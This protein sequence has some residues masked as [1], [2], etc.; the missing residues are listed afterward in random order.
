MGKVIF[1]GGKR[2]VKDVVFC[3]ADKNGV[4]CPVPISFEKIL[5]VVNVRGFLKGIVLPSGLLLDKLV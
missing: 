1:K 4:Y 3:V 2:D 5:E